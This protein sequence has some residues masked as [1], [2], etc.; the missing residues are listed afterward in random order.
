M[1]KVS[2]VLVVWREKDFILSSLESIFKNK[3]VFPFEV[4]LVMNS[5]VTDIAQAVKQRFPDVKIIQNLKNMG[6]AYAR[7]QGIAS[8]VGSYILLLDADAVLFE[9]ALER[10]VRFMDDHPEVGLLGPKLVDVNGKL[11]F[12]C[13]RD[14]TLLTPLL[15][16]LS[17]FGPVVR[18]RAFKEF[19]MKEWA[20][21]QSRAVEQVIGA[22]QFIRSSAQKEVGV[23]DNRMF[24]G[25]EDSDY[26]VRM[27]RRGYQVVYF[28]GAVVTHFEQRLTNKNLFSRL[29]F[30]NIKSMA[31]FFLKYPRAIVGIYR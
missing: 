8:A 20:H 19:H 21:D 4:I 27:R 10:M 14:H 18:S 29:G 7:N 11:Q 5:A 15:R 2:V 26:C 6:V 13:R 16:R 31:L 24:Y 1:T 3:C 23:L 22:C 12:S 25:W 28:P 17:F 30:E 9:G